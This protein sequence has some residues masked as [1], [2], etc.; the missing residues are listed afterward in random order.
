[1]PVTFVTEFPSSPDQ[2]DQVNEEAQVSANPPNGLI[3]HIASPIDG[4]MMRIVDVWESEED[5]RAFENERLL[6]AIEKVMGPMPDGAN[7]P[8]AVTPVHNF[9]KQ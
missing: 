3:V 1:M 9:I 7:E 5:L 2:Y 8:P 4:G 6:A